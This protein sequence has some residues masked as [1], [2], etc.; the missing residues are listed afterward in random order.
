MRASISFCLCKCIP[1]C[2]DKEIK[3]EES[4]ASSRHK[5]HKSGRK[6]KSRRDVPLAS[7]SD[8]AEAHGTT[9]TTTVS[10]DAGVAALAMGSS[11]A[12]HMSALEGS[13]HSSTHGGDG[14]SGGGDGG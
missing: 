13:A 4:D 7:E 1:G 6:G 12:A 2:K 14:G 10:N 8:Y 11:T 5:P 9:S 3:N